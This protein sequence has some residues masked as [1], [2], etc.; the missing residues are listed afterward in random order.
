MTSSSGRCS[1]HTDGESGPST[2]NLL[3][4]T[5]P[6]VGDDDDDDDVV[7]VVVVRGGGGGGLED[8]VLVS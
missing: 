7:V 3:C 4:L 6:L 5:T 1:I 2:P 8:R